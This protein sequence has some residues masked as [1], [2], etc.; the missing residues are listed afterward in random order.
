MSNIDYALGINIFLSVQRNLVKKILP[1]DV[2]FYAIHAS[3]KRDA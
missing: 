3:V 2:S 1:N